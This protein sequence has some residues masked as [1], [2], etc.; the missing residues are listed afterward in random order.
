[1]RI[2]DNQTLTGVFVAAPVTDKKNRGDGFLEIIYT[3]DTETSM[4][5]KIEFSNV[6]DGGANFFQESVIDKSVPAASTVQTIEYT[7]SASGTYRIPYISTPSEDKMK[8]SVKSTGGT[9]QGS[10][11]VDAL[12]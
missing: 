12:I 6:F 4:E 10:V 3:Q 1:M 7:M 2:I 8:V 11:T 5:L 9:T